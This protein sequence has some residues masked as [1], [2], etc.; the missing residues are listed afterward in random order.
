METVSFIPLPYSLISNYANIITQCPQ[1][2]ESIEL[3]YSSDLKSMAKELCSLMVRELRSNIDDYQGFV[4]GSSIED[5]A[6]KFLEDGYFDGDVGNCMPLALTNALG[7]PIF[8]ISTLL[9]HPLFVLTPR[10]PRIFFPL[11]VA[12]NHHGCG[13]YDAIAY[14][15]SHHWQ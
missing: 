5:E 11:F 13:H 6:E 9:S 1:S 3:T 7:M 15:H 2:F 10:K 8:I 4:V 14:N 12:F